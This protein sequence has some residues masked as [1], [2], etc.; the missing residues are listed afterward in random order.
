MQ[1]RTIQW[2]LGLAV[3]VAFGMVSCES[4]NSKPNQPIPGTD[5]P[6]PNAAVIQKIIYSIPSPMIMADLIK[7]TG[8]AFEPAL[9]NN[10]ENVKNYS[11]EVKKALNL[12]VYG[13]D[14]SY[15][16]MFDERQTSIKYMAAAQ[17]LSRELGVDGVLEDNLL[18]RLND[19]QD[20]RDSLLNIVSGAYADLNDYLKDNNRQTV[21]ALVVAGGWIEGLYL[22]SHHASKSKSAALKQR[23]AEQ[24]LSLS[25]LIKL[26][27]QYGDNASLKETLGDLK[28]IEAIFSTATV[29]QQGAQA[30]KDASGTM[31]IGGGTS[32]SMS[33]ADLDKL[34]K[35]V[36]EIRNRYIS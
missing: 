10:T 25:D 28:N 18:N 2:L 26:F 12:G 15:A 31:V 24:K 14:L 32:I 34:T 35:A 7:E 29:V 16:S 4:D 33:D 13:A 23:V 5:Q 19:N 8:A 11:A 20:N 9:L 1:Q 3:V 17:K 27:E 6:D 36:A 21:S 30:T 22:A